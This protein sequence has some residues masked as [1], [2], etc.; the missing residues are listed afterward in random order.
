MQIA[1]ERRA[2]ELAAEHDRTERF[3]HAWQRWSIEGTDQEIPRDAN[4]RQSVLRLLAA[5]LSDEFLVDAVDIAMRSKVKAYQKWRYFCG[6]CWREVDKIQMLARRI[7]AAPSAE[8]LVTE[9]L[10][11]EMSPAEEIEWEAQNKAHREDF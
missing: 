7:A 3:D 2:A 9:A 1:I 4:W 10:N 11:Y 8:D 5:G 6:V